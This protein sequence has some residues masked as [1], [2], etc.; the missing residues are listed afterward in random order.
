MAT[1]EHPTDRNP[2]LTDE[3]IEARGVAAAIDRSMAVVTFDVDGHVLS[4]NRN[5]LETM[6]YALDE[7][8]GQHHRM[9]CSPEHAASAEYAA[10]WRR[11]AAGEF[12]G[13]EF[14]RRRRSGED[15][16]L[17]ATYNP[18]L[19]DDGRTVKVVKVA[20]D[21]TAEKARN[22]A[23][24]A[25][26]AAIDRAQAVI[27]FELDGTIVS[28]NEHFLQTVGYG[29][30]E[31]VGR[32]HRIFCAPEDAD[33]HEYREF[34]DRLRAGHYEHGLFK[35]RRKDGA[36]LW[37][38]ATYNPILD[39][40]G[41]PVRIV[42]FASDVTDARLRSA[43]FEG[44]AAAI[45]RA[46]AVIEFDLEGHVLAA[47]D[48]FLETMGYPLAQV[49]GKHHRMFCEPAYSGTEEYRRFWER[50]AQG[51]YVTGEFKRIAKDGRE[52]WLQATY[53]PILDVDGEPVKFV[54]FAVDVTADRLAAAEVEGKLEAVER[55]QAVVE[56]DLDG[57]VLRANDNFL[58]AMGYSAREIVGQHHSLFCTQDYVVSEEYRD[59]WLRLGKGE[60]Y[61]GRFHRVGKFG[62]DVHIQAAY[63]PIFDLSGNVAKVVKYAY[64]ITA[65]VER[66][67][68]IAQ[69]TA[70][71][72]ASAK[73]LAGSID[74]V[75]ASSQTA[76][77]LAQ[78]TGVDADRGVEALRASLEAIDRIQSS[79]ASIG[80][81]VRVMSEI[82][83]Q[84]NLLAF[85]ASI[86]AARA[87]EHGVGFSVVAGEVRKLAERASDAAQQITALIEESSERVARGAEVSKRAETAFER[88]VASVEQTNGVIGRISDATRDQQEASREVTQLIHRIAES[89]V[90]A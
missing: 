40:D 27:E 83:S 41:R 49:Q 10:F 1:T 2:V 22:A 55:A 38:Q 85:N 8:A 65:Q 76:T 26:V 90:R 15:V 16:W 87:G 3:L 75:V 77:D 7:V 61:S 17:Q 56:F 68:R 74:Q 47:N 53:N 80:A 71:M 18:I 72:T 63:N 46:Q 19:D 21:V 20:A 4:G 64:D 33:A 60:F 58:R 67:E 82:A 86:E 51:E 70:E 37:L 43:E 30:E 34:W 39:A 78:Q 35:R 25:K 81:H 73:H 42:K 44:R 88:I 45:D 57:N 62:R 52:V 84:T 14:R 59:F 6:G 32:H 28:A 9:F 29:L 89:D 12:V 31:I 13:G 11:L 5:F 50:L 48:N 66:E 36:T 23:F 24:E 79:S 69:H 54:K